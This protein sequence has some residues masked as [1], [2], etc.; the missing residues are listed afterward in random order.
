MT[1]DETKLLVALC[2]DPRLN[3]AEHI[4][5]IM[6]TVKHET[7]NQFVPVREAYWLSEE[8]RKR[9]LRYYP[10]YGRGFVQITWEDNYYK[11]EL[12]ITAA[13]LATH[14]SYRE[15]GDKLG[16]DLVDNPD[17]ALR[18]DYAYEILVQGMLEGWFTGKSLADF[19]SNGHFDAVNAR[20]I[21]N[22]LDRASLIAA[23][24][25]EYLP[26]VKEK[27]SSTFPS[28][29]LSIGNKSASVQ[30]VQ[31]ILNLW[32]EQ[33]D[34]GRVLVVDGW[35][36]IR[37]ARQVKEFQRNCTQIK[38]ATGEIE[39]DTWKALKGLL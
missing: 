9:N 18:W 31:A 20:K 17:L 21:V 27:L 10:W 3:K 8:W 25:K 5:Y 29:R 34:I 12:N 33:S 26:S 38:E 22:G 30:V 4:A 2:N 19:N 7:A 6:A 32:A 35:Y 36:G 28:F 14:K 15:I 23:Y 37:T 16:T 13:E 39:K 1:K 11:A 24:A